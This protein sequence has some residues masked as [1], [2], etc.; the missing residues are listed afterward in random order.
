MINRHLMNLATDQLSLCI[1]RSF[2]RLFDS[3]FHDAGI[4]WTTAILYGACLGTV[5]QEWS[6][7]YL[8]KTLPY[9]YR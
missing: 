1:S 7:R 8:A 5:P 3:L 4:S 2:R 6:Y 9:V